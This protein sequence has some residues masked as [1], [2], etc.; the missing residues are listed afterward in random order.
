VK[1]RRGFVS[2]SSSSSFIVIAAGPLDPPEY[3]GEVID[4]SES[5]GQREFG[6]DRDRFHD[7]ESK[8]NFAFL[9]T[10]YRGERGKAWYAML[11]KVLVEVTGC[12]ALVP[13]DIKD[14]EGY[15][16]YTDWGYIDHQSAANEGANTEMFDSEE[17][18][19][20][21]LFCRKS[22]IETDNDNHD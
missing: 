12:S 10:M 21:F 20:Q 7:F 1:I 6:W 14:D 22:F 8:L 13:P 19:K 15:G 18:L 5:S 4:L 16:P 3:D 17:N 2:N 9:Q 11:V